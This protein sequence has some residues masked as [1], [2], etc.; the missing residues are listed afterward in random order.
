MCIRD[1]RGTVSPSALFAAGIA[2]SAPKWADVQWRRL[3]RASLGYEPEEGSCKQ[4]PNIALEEQ[5]G[6]LPWSEEIK[7][8]NSSLVARLS[9]YQGPQTLPR[10]LMKI[11]LRPEISLQAPY[12]AP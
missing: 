1:R 7:I 4:P 10:K 11:W 8:A 2:G 3:M 6:Q 9:A 12:T 5:P